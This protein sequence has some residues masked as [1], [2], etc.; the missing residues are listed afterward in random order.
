MIQIDIKQCHKIL[1]DIAKRIDR[2]CREHDIP[3]Y[4]IGGTMLGAVRHK[5]FI[6]W[7][8]DLDIAIPREYYDKFISIASQSLT[9][10]YKIATYL[11]DNRIVYGVA[12][13]YDV[14]TYLD[15]PRN[16]RPLMEQLGVSVDIF[17]LDYIDVNWQYSLI[18]KL[19]RFQTLLFVESTRP[20]FFK[21]LLQRIIRVC[22]PL[23]SA[24]IVS[25][26]NYWLQHTH[27]SKKYS[28]SMWSAYRAKHIMP[29]K[30]WGIPTEYEFEDTKLYGVEDYDAYLSRLMGNYMQL[31]PENK[32]KAHCDTIYLK[33]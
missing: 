7:D 27:P 3:Y 26:V 6:P 28:G 24:W 22:F 10:Q 2:I 19:I 29:T 4:I 30:I 5:G 20:S 21:S 17:P 12:K 31:P 8:D 9:S 18:L 33:D 14:N 15:D 23:K 13:V 25:F 16:S 1:L 32:R 11:T